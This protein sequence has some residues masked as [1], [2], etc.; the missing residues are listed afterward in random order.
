MEAALGDDA[1]GTS[2]SDSR[3]GGR[4][5]GDERDAGGSCSRAGRS[6]RTGE[7]RHRIGDRLLDRDRDGEHGGGDPRPQPAFDLAPAA[8]QQRLHCGA[9]RSEGLGDLV[10]AEAV[11]IP[12]HDRFTLLGRKSGEL[13]IERGRFLPA[14]R[15]LVR[16]RR[17]DR[18]CVGDRERLP[19]PGNRAPA[20]RVAGDRSEP[21]GRI[22]DVGPGE[23]AAICGQ[24]DLLRRVL[25]LV[26][27]AKEHE[28]DPVDHARV[29][30]VQLAEPRARR[31]GRREMRRRR[32]CG[33]DAHRGL[34]ASVAAT[35]ATAGPTVVVVVIVTALVIVVILVLVLDLLQHERTGRA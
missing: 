1:R 29:R 5:L 30:G 9:R 35:T 21:G 34:A 23:E 2:E 24:K 18:R 12:Q 27:V 7:S 15:G 28:A 3:T 19:H 10:V 32:G 33:L 22:A 20:A 13:G 31:R 25:R 26:R 16:R 8:K 11:E 17:H 14:D 6:S 4:E